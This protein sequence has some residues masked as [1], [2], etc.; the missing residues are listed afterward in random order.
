MHAMIALAARHLQTLPTPSSG[1]YVP[2]PELS[3]LEERHYQRAL[4][5][6]S[7]ALRAGIQRNNQAVLAASFILVYY[8]CSLLNYSPGSATP[9][10]DASITFIRGIRTIV[11]SL[12]FMSGGPMNNLIHAVDGLP[13][14]E[15]DDEPGMQ[16]LTLIDSL[17]LTSHS[18][19]HKEI[20]RERI[21]S[22][23][24][25]FEHCTWQHFAAP[26]TQELVIRFLRWQ[27]LCPPEYVQLIRSYDKAALAIL[28]HYYAAA[29]IHLARLSNGWWW[30]KDKPAYMV[31]TILDYLDDEWDEW[32]EWPRMMLLRSK[33]IS[34]E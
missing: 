33:G 24:P 22:L 5:T 26:S 21:H 9:S 14:R 2:K 25:Y 28:A 17:P 32:K 4:G 31:Q 10:D 15:P 16:L 13:S 1:T 30:W 20:Y 8:S 6:Y 12:K 18:L 19:E 23:T 7:T 27:A 34:M 11:H 29:A 3:Q